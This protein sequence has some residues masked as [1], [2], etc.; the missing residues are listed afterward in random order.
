VFFRAE[1]AANR[2]R[3]QPLGG[4]RS[5]AKLESLRIKRDANLK[6]ILDSHVG[7]SDLLGGLHLVRK[8]GQAKPHTN[9]LRIP[10]H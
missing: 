9:Y 1:A 7:C 3:A 6:G 4:L 8:S 10:L 2:T 5:V